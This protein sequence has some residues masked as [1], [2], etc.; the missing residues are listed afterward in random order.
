MNNKNN[1]INNY[2]LST[3]NCQLVKIRCAIYTRK[4]SE[5]GLELEYNSLD[6]QYDTC[7]NFVKSHECDG[8]VLINKRYDDGGFSGGNLDRPALKDLMSD[9]A[10][11][12]IDKIIIYKLDR[13]SRSN[14]DYYKLVDI[15]QR[16]NID[17][18]I[19]TQNF[20]KST[21]IGRFSLGM[22]LNFAQ[23]EREMT[24]D[25][26]KDKIRRQQALGMWTGGMVSLGYDVIDK[27]LI[28]NEKEAK[29]VRFI[30]KTFVESKSIEKTLIAVNELGFK[31]KTYKSA[32]GN[33][34][35][36]VKFNRAHL[37]TVLQNKLYIG[38]II[39]KN[40]NKV[41]NG[42]H[43]PIIDEET[44]NIVAEIFKNN[45]NTKMYSGG[46]IVIDD[47]FPTKR[48]YRIP[49]KESRVPYLLRGLM[50]C[51][52]CNSTFTPLYTVKK[53]SGIV[54]RYYKTNKSM[55]HSSDCKLGNIPAEQIERII[56]NQVYSILKSPSVVSDIIDKIKAED[57]NL[58][59]IDIN[60]NKPIVFDDSKI[61]SYLNNIEAVWDELFPKEQMEILRI[62][63]KEIIISESNVKITFKSN[64][65]LKL[66]ADAGELDIM[67]VNNILSSNQ[68]QL[69]KNSN[70]TNNFNCIQEHEINIPVD[71]KKKA[72]R[73]FISIPMSQGVEYVNAEVRKA[74]I[75]N[76]RDNA[77]VVA[78][79]KAEN[80]LRE[81]T[82]S[83]D[84]YALSVGCIASREEKNPSYIVRILN[85]VFLAPDIKKAILSGYAPIGLTL[86]DLYNCSELDW[87]DQRKK[88]GL[89]GSN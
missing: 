81:M 15:L 65:I 9:V 13:I 10:S 18:E 83:N 41:F 6:N 5:E 61:I 80:W 27:K 64:G 54:Y 19:A 7:A 44:F 16:K 38:K 31:T 51:D 71:F 45:I 30:F 82:R 53:K 36:G 67:F 25:R 37:Y 84:N 24:S 32:K 88:L 8:W 35:E 33:I 75:H 68:E 26:I 59:P 62:L 48:R 76:N 4:S 23:L 21:S 66:L 39:N 1:N 40:A 55:K 29:I 17:I 86:S 74:S 2:Q 69:Q 47:T 58:L 73:S 57:T 50:K 77:L 12:F 52:C 22:M 89:I 28:I 79:I 43:E 3:V 46:E 20:D 72:G 11:G 56:L 85:L 63:I 42:I 70:N 78:L 49:K 14:I 34:R 87:A 60:T